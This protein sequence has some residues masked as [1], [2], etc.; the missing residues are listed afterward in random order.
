MQ[1]RTVGTTMPILEISLAGGEKVIAEGENVSWY[2]P[3]MELDTSTRFGS[4]GRG[5]FMSGLKRALG[6][7]QLFLTE[8]TAPHSGGFVAFATRFPGT[9]RELAIDDG[10]H[11]MVQSGSYLV[12]TSNVEVSVGLQQKLGAG[13]FGG[14][15]VIFQRLSGQ[16][17]AWVELS[18][19]LVEY[20]LQAGQSMIVHPGHLALFR[21]GM[22]LNFFSV[23][24]LKNKLFGDS[25]FMAQIGGPG[26]IWLQSMTAAKL[27]AAIE[28]FLPDKTGGNDNT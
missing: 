18:G 16:G 5:G 22:P 1:T 2:T 7:G 21:D 13:I 17:Q 28:P 27:A 23:Q 8:Y 19:E 14:A 9:I 3:G 20:E 6:G 15:G 24:G 25:M 12:S 10:D 11:F 4:G 26:H